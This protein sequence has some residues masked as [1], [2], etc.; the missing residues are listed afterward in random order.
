ML[1]TDEMDIRKLVSGVVIR[2]THQ[3]RMSCRDSSSTLM[4]L[5]SP[6]GDFSM[7]LTALRTRENASRIDRFVFAAIVYK[8]DVHIRT[9]CADNI[10]IEIV[11][12][13]M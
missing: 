13:C 4:E 11:D 12:R 3:Q 6:S 10:F 2:P 7:D 1:N 9:A 8:L 5:A